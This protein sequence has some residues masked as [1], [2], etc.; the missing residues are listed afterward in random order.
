MRACRVWPTV[1]TGI[2]D[3]RLIAIFRIPF[4]MSARPYYLPAQRLLAPLAVQQFFHELHTLE[5]HQL[6]VLFLTP[7]ERHAH[8]PWARKDLGVF[9]RRFVRHHIGAGARITFD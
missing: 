7:I 5:I 9:D 1:E 3:T 8:L 4:D 6:R 2:K